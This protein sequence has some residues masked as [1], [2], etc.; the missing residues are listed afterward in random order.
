MKRF[1]LIALIAGTAL[2]QTASDYTRVLFPIA[3]R[4]QVPGANGSLFV[5]FIV[6]GKRG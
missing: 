3:S 6:C 2:A 1:A 4:G 5:S